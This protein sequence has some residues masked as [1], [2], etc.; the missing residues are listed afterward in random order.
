LSSSQNIP[1]VESLN[2]YYNNEDPRFQQDDFPFGE[3]GVPIVPTDGWTDN[4]SGI[5]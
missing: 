1:S 5:T 4:P 2:R 3:D